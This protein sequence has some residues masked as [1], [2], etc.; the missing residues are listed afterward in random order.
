MCINRKKIKKHFVNFFLIFG[1]GHVTTLG[2]LS[3][4]RGGNSK[5]AMVPPF[6]FTRDTLSQN[7][8]QIGPG[9][10]AVGGVLYILGAAHLVFWFHLYFR[11]IIP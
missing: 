7:F 3:R 8:N 4:A 9:V 5:I 2:P 11:T 10:W 1:G 6:V